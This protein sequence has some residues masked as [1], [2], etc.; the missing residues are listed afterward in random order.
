[1]YH[2]WGREDEDSPDVVAG[3]V[4]LNSQSAYALID[5]GSTHSFICTTTIERLSIKPENVKTSLV[6]SNPIGKNMPINL[7]CKECPVTI[8]GI[9]FPIDLYVLPNCEIDLI[10]GLDWMNKKLTTI[11]AAMTLQDDY[12]FGLPSIPVV[13]EFV[14]VFLEELLG[15]PPT[16]EVEFGIDIQPG[17]NAVSIT[18][19]QM[20][21]IELKELKKQLEE[22]QDKG[23]IQPSTS[24]WGASV[25]FVKKKDGSMR[26][27]IDYRQ[28]NR[29]TIKNKYPLPRIE[30]LFDQ[31]RDA[32]VFSKID[33]RSSY[34]QMKVK[35]ADVPKTAFRTRYGHFEFLVMPFGLTNAPAAFMDL[36]NRVFKPYL[37]KFVVI[38]ID[39]ILIYSRNKDEHAEHLRIVLQTLRECQL[40]AKFSKCELW[41]SEVAFLGHIISAKGIMVDPK[42]VQTILDWRPPRNV[43][44]VRS[45][46]GLAG[47][48]QRFVQGFS[49]IALPLTKL[50]RKDQPFEWSE[51]RQRSFDKLKQALTHAP[52]LIQPEP[53]KEFTVYSDA[54]HSGLGCVLMQG[55]NVAAYAL[56]QLKPHELNYPTHDLEL[57][58]IVFALK[59]WRH[60]L[61]GEKCHMFTDHKSLKY[62][63][64]QKD[65]NLRQ[66]RWME[67]LKDYDLV[68]DYH[69]GKANV[70]ADAISRKPNPA[71]LAI[72]AHFRLTKERKL[73]SELQ[74]QSDLVSRIRE[75]Q[76]M[77]PELQKISDNLN[78][79]HNSDFSVKS[80]GLLYFKV[81]MCVPS[82]EGLR[83]E[84]LDE[85]HQSSFLIH[86]GS[87]MMYKDLKPLYWWPGMK[88][89]IEDYVS[90]CL[91]CQK[92]KV[93]HRAPTGLL[94]PLKFPQWKW[95][96]IT[97]DFVSGLPITPRK[98][99][100]VWV[101][102][103][104][105][106]KSAH[107]ILARASMSS[108][109]LADIYIREEIR[110]HGVPISIVSDRDPK[111]TSRFWKSLQKSL[112]TRLNLS[113]A[114]HPQTDGQSERVVQI[115]EDMLRACV[116]DFGK[117]WE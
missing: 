69:P 15:L 107:F 60:Y 90:R 117:N 44:E 5:S 95:E 73:L 63:L 52:V 17:T 100:S 2:V 14:D 8:R 3:T 65:L 25:L 23:F 18:P 33:L 110:L 37:D 50:L 84:M 79:K 67:L 91:A 86:P 92:L 68:I 10:L 57:T 71:S 98:N 87:V 48:Y 76:R 7:I 104:R 72:N 51:D 106:T 113:T 114:F 62:L 32:S 16:R 4:E 24:P 20:A 6:V 112:G 26:L 64:T 88:S 42:K 103:D 39:D 111:F 80:D 66:R 83:K 1:M 34:Y 36:M 58:A 81:R 108:N 75:L 47:Y 9:P 116:I 27:C 99:D 22:L 97:M 21:P 101:I 70:V 93:E 77:D 43:G 46:L 13:S 59:I 109:V 96:R 78:A 53:G 61:Y 82:D 56:R 28:L 45:F 55:D 105:L 35:D 31:L 115:L 30:D 19:Y 49:T 40:Y 29:V 85:A 41:L 102:V 74:V 94:Q 12:D 11:F 54:S 38:F 89:A